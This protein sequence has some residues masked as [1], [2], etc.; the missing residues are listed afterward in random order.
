M[1]VLDDFNTEYHCNYEDSANICRSFLEDVLS[2]AG[3]DGEGTTLSCAVRWDLESF[4]VDWARFKVG[5][6]HIIF[7]N[8]F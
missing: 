1:K 3:A 6:V 8:L 7:W 4:R 2:E 5:E